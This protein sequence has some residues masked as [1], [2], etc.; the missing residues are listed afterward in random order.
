M[1]MNLVLEAVKE[2]GIEIRYVNMKGWK[3]MV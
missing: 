2:D 1:R 3:L